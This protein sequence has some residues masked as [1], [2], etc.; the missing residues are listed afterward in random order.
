MKNFLIDKGILEEDV[1]KLLNKADI[2]IENTTRK[3]N[4]EII[5]MYFNI[6]EMITEYKKENNSKYGDSVVKVFKDKIFLKYGSG[7]NKSNIYYAIKFYNFF[8]NN[9]LHEQKDEQKSEQIFQPAG[10]SSKSEQNLQ[11]AANSKIHQTKN[12][13]I[14]PTSGKSSK[15][16]NVSIDIFKTI[17]WSHIIEILNI[18]DFKIMN[19]YINEVKNKKLTRVELRSSIKSKSYERSIIVQKDCHITNKIEKTL[20]APIILNIKDKKRTER[21]LEDDIVK[22]VSNFKKELGSIVTFYERQYKL[23]INGLLHKVDLV[24]LDYETKHFYLNRFKNW[25]SK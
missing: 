4:Y 2:L 10:I 22:N 7:F 3:I 16:K 12:K 5:M 18:S 19:Y 17:T 21:E 24:F 9:Q 25:Q 8:P 11:P 15:H 13:Q 23:N 14:F 1:E 20:K 6:G